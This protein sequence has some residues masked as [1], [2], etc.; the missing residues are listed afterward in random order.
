[1]EV[2]VYILRC[3]DGSYYVGNTR[4]PIEGRVW[5][6]NQG[7][8]NGYTSRRR[9]V[10]LVYCEVTDSLIAAF[11]RERQLKGWSRKKKEALITHAY[12]SLP[13]LS[14]NRT[15]YPTDEH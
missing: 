15:E 2:A 11:T 3:A 10:E 13:I 5:E 7:F 4:R 6:H 14:R 8:G 12:G 1:M 9:P